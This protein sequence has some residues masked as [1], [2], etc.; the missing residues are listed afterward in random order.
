MTLKMAGG[1][2]ISRDAFK[3]KIGRVAT[4]LKNEGLR[5]GDSVALLLR[6][7]LT[8]LEVEQA[9]AITGILPVPLNWHNAPE[10]TRYVL[11]DCGAKLVVAHSDLYNAAGS[12]AFPDGVKVVILSTPPSVREAFGLAPSTADLPDA[13]VEYTAWRDACE[14]T[15]QDNPPMPSSVIYTSGTT[16]HPKGVV[17]NP[18]TAEQAMASRNALIEIYG[19]AGIEGATVRTAI[20]GPH[21]HA[22]PT[23]HAN[24][25]YSR[26]ADIVVVPR[27]DAEALL[28][29]IEKER[30]TH[31][32]MVPIM[33]SRMLKLPPEVRSAYDL[34]SLRYISHAAAPCP[35][36]VK[37]AMIEWLGP[38]ISEFYGSTE[39]GNITLCSSQ[40]WLERPGTV[41]RKLKGAGLLVVDDAG[42]EVPPNTIG[43]ILGRG[44]GL[45]DFV[46]RNREDETTGCFMNGL[47]V[48]GD[49]GYVDEDGYLFICDRNK[50]MIISGGVNIYPAEIE[51]VLHAMDDI[52]DCAVFGI[53]DEEYGE[54][55]CAH[56]QM[57]EG[58]SR[59]PK[60]IQDRLRDKL[61]GYKVPRKIVFEDALPREDSGKVKKFHL[62]APYWEAAGRRI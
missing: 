52:A 28:A 29:L 58:A 24:F 25:C 59:D 49:A 19:L 38:I 60:A 47:I 7:D 1:D 56:V 41:G 35:P 51:A 43:T 33:F 46:Y 40:E 54:S 26:G 22:A 6:N 4:A 45:T 31:L 13:A 34:S 32:N 37:R 9:A 48:P 2:P 53:P 18:R 11:E 10:E 55:I 50:D 16:G 5:E 27:F 62:R 61:A 39:M 14:P 20:I 17:R 15:F 3:Q 36:D 12:A 21:Y 44:P 30:I 42:N 8:F 57:Q 23:T